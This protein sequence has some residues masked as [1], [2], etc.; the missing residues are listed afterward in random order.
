MTL[1]PFEVFSLGKSCAIRAHDLNPSSWEP[2]EVNLWEFEA[3]PVYR[4]SS[5][6]VRGTQKS[7]VSKKKKKSCM[8]LKTDLLSLFQNKEK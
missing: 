3:S 1:P 5:R 2:E 8:S 6:I 7:Q 4:A